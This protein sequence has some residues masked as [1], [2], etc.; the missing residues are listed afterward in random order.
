MVI[1]ITMKKIVPGY[2]KA[3]YES[4]KD[5]EGFKK[6]YHLFGEFDFFVVLEASD[7]KGLA[8]IL[9]KVQSSRYILDTW[10]LLVSKDGDNLVCRNAPLPVMETSYAQASGLAAG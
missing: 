10:P 6:I 8:H 4:L 7:R 1:G 9:E 2:E 5:A 3:I